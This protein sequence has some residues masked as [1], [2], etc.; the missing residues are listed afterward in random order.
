[1]LREEQT[2]HEASIALLSKLELGIAVET[3]ESG[4]RVGEAHPPP[5]PVFPV[6]AS[7]IAEIEAELIVPR[8]AGMLIL[9]APIA[10]DI[11]CWTAFFDDRLQDERRYLFALGPA[12]PDRTGHS[13]TT[14][15]APAG[16]P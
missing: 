7:A 10:R 3:I 11:P 12:P 13:I 4:Q 14:A 9:A 15:M 16:Q 2:G 1:M 6:I 8:V 5:G